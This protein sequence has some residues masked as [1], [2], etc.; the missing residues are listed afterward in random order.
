M[1]SGLELR[2]IE[3][4]D[5]GKLNIGEKLLIKGGGRGGAWGDSARASQLSIRRRE[6]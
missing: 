3:R 1:V 4:V 6:G 5:V 2:R